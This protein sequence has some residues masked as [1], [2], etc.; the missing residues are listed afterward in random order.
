MKR[1]ISLVA[2]ALKDSRCCPGHEMW[3]CETYANRRSKRARSRDKKRE[4]R[5]ARHV[6][7]RQ[8]WSMLN[9]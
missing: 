9:E 3:P 8:V 5:Y 2:G 4:H 1:E 6:L 7:N